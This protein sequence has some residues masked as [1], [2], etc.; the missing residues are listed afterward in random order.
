MVVT[1]SIIAHSPTGLTE[2]IEGCFSDHFC[3]LGQKNLKKIN[4]ISTFPSW[5]VPFVK[6]LGNQKSAADGGLRPFLYDY[7]EQGSL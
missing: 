6:L 4:F 7:G 3:D 2:Y 1:V 5:E